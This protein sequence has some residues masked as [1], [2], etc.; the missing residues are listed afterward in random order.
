[1]GSIREPRPANVCS[2]CRE[3]SWQG[4]GGWLRGHE[5]IIRA[6]RT[7][8]NT[9]LNHAC[10]HISLRPLSLPHAP[11]SHCL[12]PSP[13][14]CHFHSSQHHTAV[15]NHKWDSLLWGIWKCGTMFWLHQCMRGHTSAVHWAVARTKGC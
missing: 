15:L 2:I 5:R 10:F 9:I 13:S 6:W 8:R 1:M 14:C 12:D 4:D 7:Q 11:L 3:G